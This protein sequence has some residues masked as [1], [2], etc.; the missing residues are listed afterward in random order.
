MAKELKYWN[1]MLSSWTADGYSSVVNF[2]IVAPTYSWYGQKQRNTSFYYKKRAP[3]WT[4]NP[5]IKE[6]YDWYM[7][8][9]AVTINEYWCNEWE[10]LQYI[11]A[12]HKWSWNM[13]ILKK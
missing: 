5:I 12:I 3:Y 2:D 6:K 11:M 7:F 9:D 4:L 8:T 13:K 10:C 1:G